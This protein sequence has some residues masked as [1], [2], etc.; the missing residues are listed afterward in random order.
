MEYSTP[1]QECVADINAVAALQEKI[2]RI[3]SMVSALS[4]T[5]TIDRSTAV[6]LE[7]FAPDAL[8]VPL[9]SFTSTPSRVNY[10][11]TLESL[12]TAIKEA[13]SQVTGLMWAA[14]KRVFGWLQTAYEWILSLF[15]TS[16]KDI[17]KAEVIS[18]A[19]DDLL[20]Q[21]NQ[22]TAVKAKAAIASV[23]AEADKIFE[24]Q[25][26]ILS[27]P[28]ITSAIHNDAQFKL[29]LDAVAAHDSFLKSAKLRLNA[30]VGLTHRVMR[31]AY[32]SKEII[33][34]ISEICSMSPTGTDRFLSEVRRYQD[35]NQNTGSVGP[36]FEAWRSVVKSHGQHGH[37]EALSMESLV[38]I[39]NHPFMKP[40]PN[41]N[42][43]IVRHVVSDINSHLDLTKQLLVMDADVGKAL[44]TMSYVVRQDLQGLLAFKE[45]YIQFY[46]NGVNANRTILAYRRK[47]FEAVLDAIKDDEEAKRIT[48]KHIDTLKRKLSSI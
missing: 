10:D 28:Y 32:D 30:A 40:L 27:N 17:A 5:K 23:Q 44:K 6:S 39:K 22:S 19:T 43:E 18:T 14:V 42:Y 15:R 9:N 4:E 24:K 7:A 35:F 2:E 13:Y 31:G 47:V 37:R 8:N 20:K 12:G 11:V 26:T 38:R 33:S 21:L 25:L 3:E 46:G 29:F 1:P 34:H 45:G 16:N 48:D 41:E 36:G